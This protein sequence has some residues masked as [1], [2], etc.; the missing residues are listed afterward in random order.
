MSALARQ[1]ARHGLHFTAKVFAPVCSE[2]QGYG[3]TKIEISVRN[4]RSERKI[5]EYG[6]F[7][8]EY[9]T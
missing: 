6:G 9:A 2:K 1:E 5:Q 7:L 3:G 8:Q 4:R